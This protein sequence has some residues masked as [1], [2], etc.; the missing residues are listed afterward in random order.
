[1]QEPAASGE[2]QQH[3]TEHFTEQA[4]A[5]AAALPLSVQAAVRQNQTASSSSSAAGLSRGTA[6]CHCMLAIPCSTKTVKAAHC[7]KERQLVENGLARF[8]CVLL[9]PEQAHACKL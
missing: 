3:V 2:G 5:R 1:M 9:G 7:K 4:Q 6:Y 8:C